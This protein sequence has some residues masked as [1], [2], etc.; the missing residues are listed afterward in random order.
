M[1]QVFVVWVKFD[2]LESLDMLRLLMN[3][4]LVNTI[5]RQVLAHLCENGLVRCRVVALELLKG[6]ESR[7]LGIFCFLPLED[8]KRAVC[9]RVTRI[10]A[11]ALSV[12]TAVLEQKLLDGALVQVSVHL[13]ERPM[14]LQTLRTLSCVPADRLTLVLLQAFETDDYLAVFALT[15]LNRY[16]LADDA[17][18]VGQNALGRED[19]MLASLGRQR[20]IAIRVVLVILL[21]CVTTIYVIGVEAEYRLAHILQQ[22]LDVLVATLADRVSAGTKI[23]R[24][25]L[26]VLDLVDHIVHKSIQDASWSFVF[27]PNHI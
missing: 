7:L 25:Q 27:L 2:A 4:S 19:G 24:V 1:L 21:I 8:P 3:D 11:A 10:I 20:R 18:E 6:G 12:K 13:L 16:A 5:F 14:V 17:L 15:R 23:I 9:S 26:P 22:L